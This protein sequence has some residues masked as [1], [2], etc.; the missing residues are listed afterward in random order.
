MLTYLFP[1]TNFFFILD[2]HSNCSY[3]F[4]LVHCIHKIFFFISYDISILFLI[5][6]MATSQP[7]TSELDVH[8]DT[9]IRTLYSCESAIYLDSNGSRKQTLKKYL[10]STAVP[11]T[12]IV[13]N[14]GF[15]QHRAVNL[16]LPTV[17]EMCQKLLE[18]IRLKIEYLKSRKI[19]QKV[20]DILHSVVV[21]KIMLKLDNYIDVSNI[22]SLLDDSL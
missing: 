2:C 22:H 19:N 12:T 8:L 3:C 10:I 11:I 1:L 21:K 6:R 20:T 17:K 13:K 5:N 15:I 14:L 9:F 16:D 7:H 4:Y 18:D